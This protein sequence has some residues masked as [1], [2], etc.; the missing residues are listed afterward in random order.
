[1][2]D[3]LKSYQ[4]QPDS[5]VWEKIRHTLRRKTLRK[6]LIG[7]GSTMV[8]LGTAIAV[9]L[10]WPQPEKVAVLHTVQVQQPV[11]MVEPF[12]EA[13]PTMVTAV[14][15][16]KIAEEQVATPAA[17][18]SS[19]PAK[20]IEENVSTVLPSPV[21]PSVEPVKSDQTSTNNTV[22][23]QP[24]R[25]ASASVAVPTP[26]QGVSVP[27]MVSQNITTRQLPE[28]STPKSPAKSV[29][30]TSVEDTIMWIPNAFIPQ[31]D[32]FELAL[33]RPRINTSAGSISNYRMTIYSRAGRRIFSTTDVNVGWDGTFNGSMMPQAAYVYVITYNDRNQLFHQRKGTVALVR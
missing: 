16:K 5:T 26:A 20:S 30:T 7:A 11:E 6:Q 23:K 22:A 27:A 28:A 1:M 3:N 18:V 25:K 14:P 19:T 9:V 13:T 21:V 33:F 31:G 4:T 17:S 8:V 15:E 29:V 12:D 10:L 32:D 24:V 2:N